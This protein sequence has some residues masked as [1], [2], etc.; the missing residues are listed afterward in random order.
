MKKL[1]SAYKKSCFLKFE[2]VRIGVNIKTISI[3][4]FISK[5][6]GRIKIC[7]HNHCISPDTKVSL[8]AV[9]GLFPCYAQR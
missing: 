7:K 2:S 9:K 5:I 8:L 3:N 6:D 4:Q 1:F